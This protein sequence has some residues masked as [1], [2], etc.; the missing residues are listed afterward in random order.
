MF[1]L[2]LSPLGGTM[3]S[4]CLT[5]LADM[6]SPS[7]SSPLGDMVSSSSLLSTACSSLISIPCHSPEVFFWI[8]IDCRKAIGF[9]GSLTP[10]RIPRVEQQLSTGTGRTEQI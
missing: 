5:P 6:T 8:V 4:A 7:S 3:S 1:S 9:L 2:S 10:G